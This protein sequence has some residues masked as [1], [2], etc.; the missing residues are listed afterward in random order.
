VDTMNEVLARQVEREKKTSRG[1]IGA[2]GRI[3]LEEMRRAEERESIRIT[4]LL[5]AY[6]SPAVWSVYKVADEA[7]TAFWTSL[8]TLEQANAPGGRP[9][10][11]SI[12][13]YGD[14]LA[15]MQQA[16]IDAVSADEP[17]FDA[18][19]AELSWRAPERA[20]RGLLSPRGVLSRRR[21]PPP[22]QAQL[23][24]D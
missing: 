16:K 6:A 11:T 3:A 17:L 20:R 8:I 15:A 24:A 5:R 7:N 19:N 13:E 12:P 18:I 14:A 9:P 2:I 10:G 23:P 22:G 1:D 4:A 21:M